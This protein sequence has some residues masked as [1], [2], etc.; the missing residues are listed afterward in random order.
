MDVLF[1]RTVRPLVPREARGAT[2]I[3]YWDYEGVL[4][5]KLVFSDDDAQGAME[6]ARRSRFLTE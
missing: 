4:E 3:G 2:G 6:V 1:A 5:A